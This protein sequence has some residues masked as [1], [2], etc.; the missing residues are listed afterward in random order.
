MHKDIVFT[1]NSHDKGRRE[2]PRHM[3]LRRA[4]LFYRILSLDY[5]MTNCDYLSGKVLL[6]SIIGQPP[7]H[8][9]CLDFII[10]VRQSRIA[11]SAESDHVAFKLS[12]SARGN[13]D[14][15][16]HTRERL[17]LFL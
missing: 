7:L 14:E 13:T 4:D 9:Q 8:S 1:Q 2:T 6:I 5:C 3:S 12:M 16:R 11:R 17:L 10:A 15:K